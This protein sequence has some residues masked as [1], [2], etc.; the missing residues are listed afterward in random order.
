M[1]NF[2]IRFD[3]FIIFAFL[4]ILANGVVANAPETPAVCGKPHHRQEWFIMQ[5][6]LKLELSESTNSHIVGDH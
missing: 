4:V 1:M 2:I 3:P 5:L 6:Y